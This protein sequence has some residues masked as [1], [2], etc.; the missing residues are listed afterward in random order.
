MGTDRASK[1]K[2]VDLLANLI[3]I[4]LLILCSAFFSV[5]EISLAASRRLRL[6]QLADD[7]DARAQR[8]LE[9]QQQPGHYFTV[10]QIGLNMVAILGGIVGEGAL[11]PTFVSLLSHLMPVTTAEK[12]GFLLSFLVV[13]SLFILFADLVPRR[14]AMTDP[15]RLA[16]RLVAPMRLFMRALAPL[17]WVFNG[18][19]NLLFRWLRLPAQRDDR[20]TMED[21]RA[22]HA[23]GTEAGV[24]ADA[25]QQVIENVFD[26]D[27]R[28]VESSMTPRERI[29]YF[30]QDEPE[31]EIRRRIAAEPHSTY[32]VCHDEID[33]VVG[34]V[35]A[36]DLFARMLRQEPIALQG[37]ASKTLIQR[38]LVV[39]DRLTLSEVLGQ[40]RMAHEDFAVV[41]NE[42]SLVVGVI[43]LNDVMSTVMGSL[44]TRQE[45]EQIVRREDGSWLMDGVTPI[46]DVLRAL[47]L[48]PHT[49]PQRGQYDT[50]AGLLMV[51][52]RRIPRRTDAF[53]LEGYRFEVMDVDGYK[54]DQVMVTPVRGSGS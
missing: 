54:I 15:E 13:T 26:L 11:T 5:A 12:A 31:D 40:F 1:L 41:V 46:V 18:L 38:V 30:L 39:P 34:Y 21:I 51:V 35:D 53:T 33:K 43:T 9:I 44:V 10:V 52:L 48:D 24:L 22:M 8:V 20:I 3:V 47:E 14:G 25:E 19:A 49:L 4:L 29:V 45:E 16:M 27:T 17:A 6:R 50:L 28:T 37:E 42:Y 32:L 23:A 2:F 36:A 7:G